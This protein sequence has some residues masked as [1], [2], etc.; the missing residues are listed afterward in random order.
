MEIHNHRILSIIP[1]TRYIGIAILDGTNLKEWYVKQV[2]GS[3]I[4][5]RI[6]KV[7]SFCRDII[8]QYEIN[9]FVIKKLHHARS[10]SN[11]LKMVATL[12]TLAQR[13]NICVVEF[14]IDQIKHFFVEGKSNKKKLA[15]EVA[16]RYP[17][18]FHELEH[19]GKN[20]NRYFTRMFEAVALGTVC[21]HYLERKQQRSKNE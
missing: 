5:E 8:L 11:L 13:M 19:E 2:K 16:T 9:A 6:G 1:G 10:S 18:L 17:F 12:K 20:K 7:K 14:S 4:T 21:Y 15:E 3:S